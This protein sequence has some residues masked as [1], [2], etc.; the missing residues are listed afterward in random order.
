MTQLGRLFWLAAMTASVVGLTACVSADSSS[1]ATRSAQYPFRLVDETLKDD[2]LPLPDRMYWIDNDRLV[3]RADVYERGAGR[4]EN[5]SNGLYLWDERT[6]TLRQLE[7]IASDVCYSTGVLSYVARRGE[8]RLYIEGPVDRPQARELASGVP[9]PRRIRCREVSK[10]SYPYPRGQVPLIGGG[11]YELRVAPNGAQSLWFHPDNSSE[12]I[13]LPINALHT[14]T[15][16]LRYSE[17]TKSYVLLS[18]VFDREKGILPF[19]ELALDGSVRRI[20]LPRGPWAN[21]VRVPLPTARGWLLA[22]GRNGV[23]L[24]NGSEIVQISLGHV[25]DIAVSPNGCRAAL[26]MDFE[27][28]VRVRPV[29]V[30]TV[31]LCGEVEHK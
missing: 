21:G 31:N 26:K 25:M 9:A 18:S 27:G 14:G 28:G 5:R 7:Q 20:E 11:V 1:T 24:M 4:I 15:D 17:F 16:R 22:T 12:P 13:R 29:P 10:E 30:Y 2:G 19:W 23:Y 3:F 8:Q 6:G